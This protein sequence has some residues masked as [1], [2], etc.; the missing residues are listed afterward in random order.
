MITFNV[1]PFIGTEIEYIKDAVELQHICGDG[2]YTKL[3]DQWMEDRFRANK[4]LLTTSGSS[5]LD[6][7]ALLCGLQPGDEVIVPAYT[8]TAS[9]SAAVHCGA[10]IKFVDIQKDGIHRLILV[11][12]VM[13]FSV[14]VEEFLIV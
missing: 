5:A 14:A 13:L 9:A 6:M 7:A 1:A 3:C 4:V 8:Y 10:T 11:M 2:K 12:A